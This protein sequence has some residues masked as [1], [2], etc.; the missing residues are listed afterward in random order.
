MKTALD[1]GAAAVRA[2]RTRHALHRAQPDPVPHLERRRVL[3]AAGRDAGL[4]ARRRS[5]PP[6]PACRRRDRA[7][8]ALEHDHRPRGRCRPSPAHCGAADARRPRSAAHGRRARRA[9]AAARSGDR[10][11]LRRDRLGRR[12]CAAVRAVPL[13]AHRRRA[14][15]RHGGR[16]RRTSR[17]PTTAAPRRRPTRSPRCP[18]AA[19]RVIRSTAPRSR[20]SRSRRACR[21]PA[22]TRR[23]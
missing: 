3:P 20:R 8:G 15:H 7:R 16:V 17:W 14:G 19:C 6:A 10:P 4:P 11:A 9:G 13:Q 23:R 12:R 2:A 22:A 1:A 21:S 5:Q 18:A